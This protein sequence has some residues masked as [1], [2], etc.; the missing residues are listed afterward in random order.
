[1]AEWEEK[2]NAILSDPQAM[3]QIASI[4]QALSKPNPD[5][6]QSAQSGQPSQDPAPTPVTDLGSPP[7]ASNPPPNGIPEDDPSGGETGD[8]PDPGSHTQEAG[9]LDSLGALGALGDLDPRLIQTTLGLLSE[10]NA[11]DDRKTAL[12]TALKPFLKPE[13]WAKVDKAIQIA[14]LSRMIRVGLQLF[15]KDGQEDEGH[16]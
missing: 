3:G 5:A 7:F 6:G 12:L 9:G 10:Y 15:K 16:V 2:L 1:M 8:S 4:A 11:T 14:K 13:R